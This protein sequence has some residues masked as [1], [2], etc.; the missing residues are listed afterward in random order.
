MAKI[1]ELL[2]WNYELLKRLHENGI[3]TRDFLSV[4]IYRNYLCMRRKGYK[5]TYIVAVLS[6]KHKVGQRTIYR[7]IG[8]MK[9]DCKGL[10]V[11]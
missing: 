8:Q 7:I 5:V 10:A 11:E 3:K 6:D 9:R 1:Y 2:S 4:D